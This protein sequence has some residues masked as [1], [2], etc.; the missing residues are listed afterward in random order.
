VRHEYSLIEQNASEEKY[1]M[2][3]QNSLHSETVVKVA[4]TKIC[5]EI[6]LM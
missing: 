4:D 5:T 3:L 1:E 6:V 2:D